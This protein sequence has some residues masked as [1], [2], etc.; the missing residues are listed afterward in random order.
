MTTCML[1]RTFE[2]STRDGRLA[3]VWLCYL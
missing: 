1:L 2:R 3:V